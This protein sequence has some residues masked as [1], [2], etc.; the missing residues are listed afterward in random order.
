MLLSDL[1]SFGLASV[2][3]ACSS[4]ALTST[5]SGW[6]EC[7]TI[8]PPSLII[9][10][11]VGEGDAPS[12]AGGEIALGTYD[13][14]GQ[15]IYGASSLTADEPAETYIFGA[16]NF[17]GETLNFAAWAGTWSVNQTTITLNESCFCKE[18]IGCSE[19]FAESFGDTATANNSCTSR[20]T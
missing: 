1:F 9:T 18:A 12:P 2:I 3:A 14:T 15:T 13:L 10:Q 17:T 6:N 7:N 8:P 20:V 11:Q 4:S 5:A 16:T 19:P